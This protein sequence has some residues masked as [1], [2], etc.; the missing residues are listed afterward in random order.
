[1]VTIIR[2][3]PL[4]II[5]VLLYAGV[6]LT[7]DHAS[8]RASLDT[9]LFS[10]VLPSGAPWEMTRGHG[11]LML[12]A[13]LLFVEI[14]KSTSANTTALVENGL[15][16]GLFVVCFILFLLNQVFGTMEFFLIMSMVLIDFMAGFVVMTISARRDVTWA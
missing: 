13:T 16:F 5:P 12:T 4:L 10:M 2:A 7:M 11:L 9:I 3:I 1:M 15:A 8:V 6:A 14:A